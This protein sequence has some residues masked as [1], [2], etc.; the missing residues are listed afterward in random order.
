M[1]RRFQSLRYVCWTGTPAGL[2]PGGCAAC[3]RIS[4]LVVPS[5]IDELLERMAA[6]EGNILLKALLHKMK[7]LSMEERAKGTKLS[8]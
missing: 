7:K 2:L 6:A 3:G 8:A 4:Y 5:E 1:S